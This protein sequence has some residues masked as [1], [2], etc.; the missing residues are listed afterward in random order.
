[1]TLDVELYMI[2]LSVVIPV[3]DEEENLPELV[4]RLSSVVQEMKL[5]YEIIFVTDINRDN[6]VSVLNSLHEKNDRVKML[7]LSNGLG[8]HIAAIAGLHFSRGNSVVIMDGDLEDYPEDIPK[9]YNKLQ[10]GYDVVYGVRE[11]KNESSLRNLFSKSF[12][13]LLNILSDYKLDHNTN[14]FRIMSKR[15]VEEVCKFKENEPSLTGLTSVVGFPTAKVVATSG[16]RKA[17]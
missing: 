7:K 9:L 12:V 2:D 17:G 15:T 8:Q 4:S 16:K 11:R 5:S 13:R 10:E 14:M 6:T 3:K 1:M